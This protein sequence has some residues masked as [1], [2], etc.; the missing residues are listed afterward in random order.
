MLI[1]YYFQK[2]MPSKKEKRGAGELQT[3]QS[4]IDICDESTINH[5]QIDLY[6]F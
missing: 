6:I 5:K 3:S 2:E 1:Q 4:G